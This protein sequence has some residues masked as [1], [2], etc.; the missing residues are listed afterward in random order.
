MYIF[1]AIAVI[2]TL[3]AVNAAAVN[4]TTGNHGSGSHAVNPPAPQVL[5]DDGPTNGTIEGFFIDGP[6]PGPFSQWIADA[7]TATGSGTVS[8]LDFGLWV[9]A[10]STPSTIT[11]WLGTTVLDNSIGGGTVSLTPSDYTFYIAAGGYDVYN[12]SLTG[13]SS[14]MVNASGGYVLTLG[15]ANDSFGSQFD[16]WDMN[17]GAA[18]CYFGVGGSF[19]GGCGAPGEAFTLYTGGN[20]TPEPGSI[21]MFG[22]GILGLAGVLRRKINL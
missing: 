19:I 22:S 21:I 3:S 15:N 8:R 18:T 1:L 7:F 2:A 6:N 9:P 10:G 11:W 13:L 5:Y 12:V 4:S 16:A 14:S 17:N 20:S